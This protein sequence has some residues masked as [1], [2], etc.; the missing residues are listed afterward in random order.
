MRNRGVEVYLSD[1]GNVNGSDWDMAALVRDQESLLLPSHE[2]LLPPRGFLSLHRE[3][4][5]QGDFNIGHLVSLAFWCIGSKLYRDS[6]LNSSASNAVELVYK[7][8]VC[9]TFNKMNFN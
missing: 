8:K 3:L 2:G 7:K 9:L 4:I 6:S 1:D 5:T